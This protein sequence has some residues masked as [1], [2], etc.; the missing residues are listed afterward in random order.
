LRAIANLSLLAILS[1]A[2]LA[3]PQSSPSL[4]LPTQSEHTQGPHGLEGWTLNYS[5][6]DHPGEKFPM[7]LVIARDGKVLQK[8]EGEGFV[9]KWIFWDAGR[10]VAFE[11]GPFH[12]GLACVLSDVENG[13]ELARY[14]CFHG[15]P[16][17]A[18]PWLKAL[19]NAH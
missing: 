15:I 18:P 17:N 5:V 9:W 7:T 6:P 11:S 1:V 14:D 8:F 2:A 3:S 16:S 19:E 10:E 4:D 13:K 12:F